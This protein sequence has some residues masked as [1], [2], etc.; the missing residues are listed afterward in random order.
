MSAFLYHII[1]LVNFHFSPG[2]DLQIL[3]FR[4]F[5]SSHASTCLYQDGS[6]ITHNARKVN[7]SRIMR[8]NLVFV[9]FP[10][11]PIFIIILFLY[12]RPLESHCGASFCRFLLREITRSIARNYT[13]YCEKLHALLRE[14]TRSIVR[15][16]TLYSDKSDGYQG[17]AVPKKNRFMSLQA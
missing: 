7:K 13:L 1:C 4:E 10:L 3:S 9:P 8:E 5:L 12:Y 17:C 16:Y 14:I 11:I 2:S 6:I 15:N